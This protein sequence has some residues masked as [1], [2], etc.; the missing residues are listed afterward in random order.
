MLF[1]A[2]T[3]TIDIVSIVSV[4]VILSKVSSSV[5]LNNFNHSDNTLMLFP[6]H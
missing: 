3:G 2:G 4:S 1:T 6:Q 5:I